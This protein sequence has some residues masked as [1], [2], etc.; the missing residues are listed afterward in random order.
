MKRVALCCAVVGLFVVSAPAYAQGISPTPRSKE[1]RKYKME[2][3]PDLLTCQELSQRM[4]GGTNDDRANLVN[5][6]GITSCPDSLGVNYCMRCLMGGQQGS[7]WVVHN[8]RGGVQVKP[9]LGC[10][11]Q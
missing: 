5:T 7:L 3:A 11:C 4:L 8:T 10:P 6:Y 2:L 9:R 1:I